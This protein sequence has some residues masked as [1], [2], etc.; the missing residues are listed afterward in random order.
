MHSNILLHILKKYYRKC[1]W[2]GA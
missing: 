1:S 2:I